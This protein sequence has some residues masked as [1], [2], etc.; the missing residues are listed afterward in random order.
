MMHGGEGSHLVTGLSLVRLWTLSVW[1]RCDI[2]SSSV[3]M[4]SSCRWL[5]CGQSAGTRLLQGGVCV[6]EVGLQL[7]PAAMLGVGV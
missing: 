6:C 4:T 2:M 1:L 3:V 5:L 7:L